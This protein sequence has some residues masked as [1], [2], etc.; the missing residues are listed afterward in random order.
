M[1]RILSGILIGGILFTDKGKQI[2]NELVENCVS[3]GKELCEKTGL[4]ETE[5]TTDETKKSEDVVP[6]NDD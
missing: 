3:L 2:T 5:V 6:K 4:Y 1:L